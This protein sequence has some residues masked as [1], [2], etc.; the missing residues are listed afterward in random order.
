MIK[1]KQVAITDKVRIPKGVRSL[2]TQAQTMVLAVIYLGSEA[3]L[4][5]LTITQIAQHAG[6]SIGTVRGAIVLAAELGVLDIV[7]DHDGKPT[8]IRNVAI[9]AKV[10]R[11]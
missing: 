1:I 9:K 3:D 7:V 10:K 2:F 11:S 4:C 5:K 6:I 8:V